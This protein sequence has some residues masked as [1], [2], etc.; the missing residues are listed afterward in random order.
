MPQG[1]NLETFASPTDSNGIQLVYARLRQSVTKV[2]KKMTP[3]ESTTETWDD[4]AF[5]ALL[6]RADT[7]P[8]PVALPPG[9]SERVAAAT[10]ARPRLALWETLARVLRPAPTR[11]ALAGALTA[12]VLCAVFLPRVTKPELPGKPI[13]VGQPTPGPALL[14]APGSAGKQ[15]QKVALREPAAPEAAAALA[16]NPKSNTEPQSSPA[17]ATLIPVKVALKPTVEKGGALNSQPSTHKSATTTEIESA[18]Q[19]LLTATPLP[20]TMRSTTLKTEATMSAPTAGVG[21]TQQEASALHVAHRETALA[22]ASE[23]DT[24]EASPEASPSEGTEGASLLLRKSLKDSVGFQMKQANAIGSLAGTR[25]EQS[26]VGTGL[27][28]VRADVK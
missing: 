20:V 2:S 12:G 3:E 11:F 17:R 23:P 13:V 26:L 19:P 24:I 18:S 8:S 16:P 6:K 7:I 27:S 25:G 21:V 15:E 9:L 28:V 5:A 1:K 14:S 22:S 4:E 10:Y